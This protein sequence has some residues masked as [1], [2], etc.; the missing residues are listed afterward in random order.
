MKTESLRNELLF[1]LI[2]LLF[3]SCTKEHKPEIGLFYD[4]NISLDYHQV[5]DA[6]K[7]LADFYDEA[8]LFEK[9]MTDSG[10]PLHLFMIS[11][12]GDFDPGSV[13][14]KGKGIVLINN[15]I[16]AGEPVGIDASLQYA[17]Y[18]LEKRDDLHHLLDNTVIAIIP[19]YNI[20]G[21]LNR[22]PFHR[23]NQSGP[24]LKGARRNARNLDLNRDFVKQDSKNSRSFAGIFHYL[25]PDVFVDTHTTNGMDHQSVMT[26]I[27][28]MHQR[29]SGQMGDF[30][31]HKM[32]PVLYERMNNE[33]TWGMIPYLQL[34][35]RQDVRDGILAFND[36]PNYSSGYGS[37]FNTFSFMTETLAYKPFSERVRSTI[38]FLRILHEFSS[39]NNERIIELRQE[40]KS[41][42]R[43]LDYFV[44]GWETD[45]GLSEKVLFRGYETEEFSGEFTKRSIRRY[46]H[47]RPWSDSIPFYDKFIPVTEIKTP[48]AYIVPGAWNEITERMKLN[49]V[50]VEYLE[51]D[52][53]IESEITYINDYTI[54]SASNQGRNHVVVLETK[55][56]LGKRQ[57]HRGDAVIWLN[58][59]SNKYVVSMLEA[60]SPV[61]FLSWGMFTSALESGEWFSLYAFEPEAMEILRND[62]ELRQEFE[63]RISSDDEFAGDPLAQLQ[64]VYDSLPHPETET[65]SNLYPVGRLL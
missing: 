35:N 45:T 23:M 61:S 21:L 31:R 41:T 59:N 53:V 1:L 36:N 48:R 33:T 15:G 30:F 2:C 64:F 34:L 3:V 49:G 40:A 63:R 43:E 57:F 10:K 55:T 50:E 42:T 25:D 24:E 6:Y 58:Q 29:L 19:V 4:D 12:G 32:L 51:R 26:L 37:L 52:S 17:V 65:G 11:A 18:L 16:H 8:A 9:G 22:S 56:R 62:R 46:D 5:I 7:K 47:N 44:A 20:G 60:E 54:S 38:D 27:P 39:G 13:R 14:N 28:T